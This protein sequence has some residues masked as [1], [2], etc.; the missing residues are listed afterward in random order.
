MNHASALRPTRRIDCTFSMPTSPE[1]SVV[2]TNGAMSMLIMR[3]KI[4]ATIERREAIVLAASPAARWHMRPASR[5][6]TTLVTIQRVGLLVVRTCLRRRLRFEAEKTANVCAR[7]PPDR[8]R[9][10]GQGIRPPMPRA[11]ARSWSRRATIKSCKASPVRSKTV[12]SVAWRFTLLLPSRSS[13]S[14]VLGL[15]TAH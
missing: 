1:T 10:Q 14:S 7:V 12:T 11:A 6:R 9:H 4:S 2:N 8:R 3:K 15:S 5:P 13:P